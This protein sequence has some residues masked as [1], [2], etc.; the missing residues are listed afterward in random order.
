MAGREGW[1]RVAGALLFAI[2]TGSG[3][4]AL[5]GLWQGPSQEWGGPLRLWLLAVF[6]MPAGAFL[7]GPYTRPGQPEKSPEAT[8]D[9]FPGRAEWVLAGVLIALGIFLRVYRLST[10]PPG[11]FVDETNAAGDALRLMDGW[12]GSPFGVGWYETPLLYAY[13]LAGLFRLLGTTYIT[14]KVA[15]LIP[16]VL[17]L[18]AFYFLGRD[19][20]GRATGITA[21]A[22][23][24]FNRWHL[25]MSR[26]GWNE[27]APPLFL[28]LTLYFLL[29]GSRR[30]HTGHFVLAG[31]LM[32]LGMY[33]Y[34]A[35]RLVVLTVITYLFYRLLVQRGYLRRAWPGLALF[36]LAYLLTFGPLAATYAHHPFTF[37]NRTRQVSILN[38]MQAAYRPESPLPAPVTAVLRWLH[39]P[40]KVSL[41]P[42][43]ES[44]I[45]HARMFLQEGDHNPRHNIPGAPMLDPVTG[46]LFILGFVYAL[47][48][49]RDHRWGLLVI[50]TVVSLLGGVLSLVREAP[51]AYRTLTVVPAVCLLAG[52]VLA[53]GGIRVRAILAGRREEARREGPRSLPL[54]H[55]GSLLLTFFILF[56][57]LAVAGYLNTTAFF[58]HWAR[59][60]RVWQAFSPMETAV[61]R[62]VKAEIGPHNIYLSPTLYWGSPVR[63]LTYRSKGDGGGLE[64]PPFKVIQP[65][66]DLPLAQPIRANTLFLLE[67]LYRNLLVLFTSYYPHARAALFTGPHGEPLFVRVSIP[68]GDVMAIR[69]LRAVYTDASGETVSRR[70]RTVQHRWPA[71]FP[72]G[73]HPRVIHWQGSI[74]V[75]RSARYDFRVSGQATLRVDHR[76]WTASR[77]LGKGLHALRIE[78]VNPGAPGRERLDL[79]WRRGK[80]AWED[81]P[82]AVLFDVA[83]P[84]HGL[85]GTYYRGERW[86]GPPVFARVDRTLLMAWIDPEPLTG[87]FSVTW[88][89]WLM[90][91][92]GGKYRLRLGADDGVRLWVDG[93]VVGESLRPGTVNQVMVTLPLSAGPHAIRVDYFQRGGAKALAFYWQPPKS[94]ETVVPPSALYPA[95]SSLP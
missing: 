47:W 80:G 28:I 20:F 3:L 42:L 45:K 81:V 54:K 5:R 10:I 91:P 2:G 78:Q 35:S 9:P 53:R 31:V 33:T 8:K 57:P 26:W 63:F 74:Y 34:L 62:E 37:L 48:R 68:L 88:T 90:A 69:G 56:I 94:P 46:I 50:W 15:S 43:E 29:K 86:Q 38:D 85:L 36:L 61:A 82:E 70:E 67:P 22:F 92:R 83:P 25:T 59:D 13:Y 39:L 41:R 18:M 19:L 65:V 73:S 64:H 93:R 84:Q 16:A 12:R 1:Q 60:P 21:L 40:A 95:L 11:I 27:L 71:D 7:F 52:E 66:E 58:V 79:Q 14:L 55:L 51:Q 49:W 77:F 44:A 24:V 4:A 89:G 76:L 30:R 75:P 23:L 87:A 72:A 32:G 6:L 17:T